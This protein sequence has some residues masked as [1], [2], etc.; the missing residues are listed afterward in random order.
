M[1]CRSVITKWALGQRHWYLPKV[2]ERTRRWI[3]AFHRVFLSRYR[4]RRS[5]LR[6]TSC[7]SVTLSYLTPSIWCGRFAGLGARGFKSIAPLIHMLGP[8]EWT[9]LTWD[10][11]GM[12]TALSLTLH[13]EPSQLQTDAVAVFNVI[14]LSP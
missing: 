2:T 6:S 3:Y 14:F 5:S 10:Y 9:F 4:L 7:Y 11:R 13:T 8:D 12:P 1:A